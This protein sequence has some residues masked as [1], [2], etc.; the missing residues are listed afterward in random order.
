ML[1]TF[2]DSQGFAFKR[3]R[4]E[5]LG[6]L[7]TG[8]RNMAGIAAACACCGII[9]GVVTLT[10]L[11]LKMATLITEAAGGNLFLT[12]FFRYLPRSF[13]AWDCPRRPPTSSWRP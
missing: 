9:I 2:R 13:S 8:A 6:S 1:P 4:K 7:E 3:S 5:I 10:G 11:G 12:L